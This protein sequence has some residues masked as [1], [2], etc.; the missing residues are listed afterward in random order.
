MGL[1]VHGVQNQLNVNVNKFKIK[2]YR[3]MGIKKSIK[4]ILNFFLLN[5]LGVIVQGIAL[6]G[7][8][9]GF[10]ALFMNILQGENCILWLLF[11][12]L[13]LLVFVLWVWVKEIIP[14]TFAIIDNKYEKY[15][16]DEKET[17]NLNNQKRL[18]YN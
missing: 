7:L 11:F 2:F 6:F 14:W 3:N 4:R 17:G 5:I 1:K 12:G 13:P 9:C 18:D 8:I 16:K 15:L 10:L